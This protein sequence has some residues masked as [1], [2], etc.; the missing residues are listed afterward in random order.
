MKSLSILLP[1]V[2]ALLLASPAF[3]DPRTNEDPA[4]GAASLLSANFGK[5]EREIREAQV[6][7]YDPARAINLG[8]ALAMS[9]EKEKAAKQFRR[10][11]FADEVQVVVADGS[12]SSSHDV[13][14]RALAALERGEFGR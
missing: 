14:E 2:A 11:L 7:K 12:T 3:A 4:P 8:I 10:A 1:S 5:A 13:A 9:G 6:S